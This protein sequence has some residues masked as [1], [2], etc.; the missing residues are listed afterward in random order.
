MMR[1]FK[2]SFK[3][4]RIVQVV[5]VAT[6]ENGNYRLPYTETVKEGDTLK[7]KA[8][9]HASQLLPCARKC[10]YDEHVI[11]AGIIS[12]QDTERE[13]MKALLNEVL[14]SIHDATVESL[15]SYAERNA[16]KKAYAFSFFDRL[17][18]TIFGR[19]GAASVGKA[20]DLKQVLRMMTSSIARNA[21][22][23]P[24]YII[25]NVKVAAILADFADYTPVAFDSTQ[26]VVNHCMLYKAGTVHGMDIYVSP[27]M[28][29]NDCRIMMGIRVG[30]N[31]SGHYIVFDSNSLKIEKIEAEQGKKRVMNLSL[32]A[33][34]MFL[35]IS[36]GCVSGYLVRDV[37][38]KSSVI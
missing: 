2:E 9:S 30:V 5:D 8:C 11:D 37:K 38:I 14:A 26:P 13:L 7:V 28:R 23:R 1:I 33:N 3:L 19:P 12:V 25:T 10:E 27:K 22:A 18:V 21:G 15:F 20:H 16:K 32:R 4:D 34:S 17:R 29:W 35:G 31:R 24:T 6:D 36:E